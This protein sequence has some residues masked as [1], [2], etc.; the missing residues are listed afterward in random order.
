MRPL[1]L[2]LA[3]FGPYKG[4]AVVNFE[5]LDRLFLVCGPTG[6]GKTT[7]FDALTYALYERT[8]GTR[9]GLT[10]QLASHHAPEGAVPE[11]CL[12]FALGSQ[13]WR[14]TR[15]L[16]HRV[17]R[18]KGEGWTEREAQVLLEKKQDDVWEAVPGKR[19]DLNRRLEELIGLS[20]EEFAKIVVLPQGDF[21]RFLE[22]STGD[23]ERMLQKLF[24]VEAYERMVEALKLRAKTVEE[25]RR[26]WEDR[27]QELTARLG[28]EADNRPALEAVW[29]QAAAE[30]RE[31][32]E[33]E[34]RA[35]D[36]LVRLRAL[37]HDW[38]ALT[39]K[40][41][42]KAGLEAR[43]A[44]Y[45]ADRTRLDRA[46][47]ARPS[48]GDLDRQEAIRAEGVGLRAEQDR[49]KEALAAVEGELNAL[50]A[51]AGEVQARERRLTELVKQRGLAE[52]QAVRWTEAETLK[53]GEWTARQDEER[54]AASA[55]R[56]REA[57]EAALAAMPP[58]PQDS[59][60]TVILAGLETARAADRAARERSQTD[61]RRQGLE[62][63]L[64]AVSAAGEAARAQEAAASAET[65]LWSQIVEALKAAALAETLVAN[66][67]CPVCGSTDHPRP[68]A[69]PEA[70]A[71]APARL[72]AA[73]QA[74]TAARASFSA[75]QGRREALEA[76][77]AALP[78][79]LPAAPGAEEAL[80]E[81]QAR[82]DA[83]QAWTKAR[84]QARAA[85]DDARARAGQA[86][87]EHQAAVQVRERWSAKLQDL[88]DT[89]PEDPRPGLKLLQEEET[90]LRKRLEDDRRRFEDLGKRREG[91][92]AKIQGLE[93]RLEAQRD[94]YRRLQASLE[95]AVAALGWTVADL[96]TAWLSEAEFASLETGI[97]AFDRDVH[98]LDG[99]TAALEAK[100]PSGPPAALEPAA[101]ELEGLRQKRQEQEARA[102]E[103]EFALRER[104]KIEDELREAGRQKQ[105]LEAD[106]QR[107]VPLARAL[108]GHNGLNL[109][110]T[111]WVLVQALEQV[112]RSATHRLASMSGGRYALKVQTRGS[113]ARRDW[114]LDLAVV[115][116]YTGQERAVGTLSGGEK[117]MTSISLALGLADVIQ[118]RSGGLKLEAI[119]I[120]EGFGT[121]DDQSL[122]RAMAILHDLGKN[123]SVGIISHVAELRSR[124][125]SR[126]EVV[127]GRDGSW[128]RQQ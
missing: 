118:E 50:E 7:L 1:E 37:H 27:W 11:V 108:D 104:D 120:D 114:G 28:P 105:A 76:Q 127:K 111:T 116:G 46:R 8:A 90:S 113:D 58:E 74:L 4:N 39:A 82:F 110:L 34:T 94:E 56:A 23:R 16:R 69:W 9:G 78:A 13:Q 33:A 79:P 44:R 12:R 128:L 5:A 73:Q 71:E 81:A 124:I 92:R 63:E 125:T 61:L 38:N 29:A 89:V 68:A 67:P 126:V 59:D 25:A 119:F 20:A 6:A 24:P 26:R 122:D 123:R 96:K 3:H 55:A 93:S 80:A 2:R 57:L 42:E 53:A 32:S 97:A 87:R 88:T 75:A 86:E 101:A 107:L 36:A 83:H 99:E 77:W 52:H 121:L 49:D 103:A 48:K 41:Q 70:S 47:K 100:F 40:R 14:V 84:D 85:V 54:T 18:K 19:S 95:A 35:S 60:L 64:A 62:A 21:Q 15:Q 31:A 106:F 112:A 10:D 102:K 45:E 51:L 43:R 91:L 115:D 72:E 30:A 109:R 66:Q 65:A 98:R 17:Q 117:F 22:S